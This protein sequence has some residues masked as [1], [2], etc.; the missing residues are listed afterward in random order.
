MYKSK[1]FSVSG[2]K[3]KADSNGVCKKV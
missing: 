1:T 3:W 2:V